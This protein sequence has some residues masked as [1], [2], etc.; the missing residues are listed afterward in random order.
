MTNWRIHHITTSPHHH[1]S[2]GQAEVYVKIS[3]TILQKP[4]DANEDPH[5]AMMAYRT[6]PVGPNT[7]NPM[8]LIHGCRSRGNLPLPIAGLITKCIVV[9]AAKSIKNQQMLTKINLLKDKLL[10]KTPPKIMW[11]KAKEVKYMRNQ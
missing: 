9:E 2:N 5:L 6:T 7:P 3:K 10:C 8:E 1:Q 4:K 11:K